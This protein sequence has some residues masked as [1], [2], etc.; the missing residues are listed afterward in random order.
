MI[1]ANR[2]F[3]II[4]Y[5]ATMDKELELHLSTFKVPSVKFKFKF[6]FKFNCLVLNIYFR[7]KKELKES[8]VN[9]KILKKAEYGDSKIIHRLLDEVE[10]LIKIMATI[11]NNKK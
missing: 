8:S 6:K 4:F 1:W 10:Q 11:I 5:Q 9:L 7:W 3:S 2:K